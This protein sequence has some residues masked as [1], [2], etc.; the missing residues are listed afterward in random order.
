VADPA[1]PDYHRS[2]VIERGF[3]EVDIRRLVN[4]RFGSSPTNSLVMFIR[5]N[6]ARALSK[7]KKMSGYLLTSDQRRANN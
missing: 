5:P 6:V 3:V 7:D 2:F 4:E 1:Y